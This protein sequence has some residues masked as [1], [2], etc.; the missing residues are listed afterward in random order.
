VSSQSSARF[1]VSSFVGSVN[2]LKHVSCGYAV[3]AC[4]KK[5]YCKITLLYMPQGASEQKLGNSM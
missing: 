4:D 5:K 3:A 2:A 1:D